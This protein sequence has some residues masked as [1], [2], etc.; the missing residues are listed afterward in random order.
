[1]TIDTIDSIA[2]GL[3]VSSLSVAVQAEE[4]AALGSMLRSQFN[5]VAWDMHGAIQVR[6]TTSR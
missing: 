5:I 2:Q 1:M 3:G 6:T 4:K